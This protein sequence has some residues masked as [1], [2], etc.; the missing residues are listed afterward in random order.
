[1]ATYLITGKTPTGTRLINVNIAGID[2]DEEVVPELDVVHAVR[3]FLLT[4][5]GIGQA[6]CL[7]SEQITTQV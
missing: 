4:V 5:P 7:K 2:Q 6:T 1:M 3:D